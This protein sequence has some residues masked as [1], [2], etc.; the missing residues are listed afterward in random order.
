MFLIGFNRFLICFYRFFIGFNMFFIGY[1]EK[2]VFGS[3][4]LRKCQT[5]IYLFFFAISEKI[6]FRGNKNWFSSPKSFGNVKKQIKYVFFA[7]SE[8]NGFRGKKWFNVL[9]FDAL[10]NQ[11]VHSDFFAR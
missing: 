1:K 7:I 10:I 5:K 6:G 9:I 2:L 8:K 4:K 3:Q 11:F